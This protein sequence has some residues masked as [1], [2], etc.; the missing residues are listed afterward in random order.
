MFAKGGEV[1]FCSSDSPHKLGCEY[2]AGG[3][4]VPSEMYNDP[5]A[6][7][8]HA[9]IHHGL[10]GVLTRL[11]HSK[12]EDPHK[13]VKDY[14]EHAKRGSKTLHHHVEHL[15]TPERVAHD[16]GSREAL[17]AH[18]Q[19]L[20]EHPEKLLEVGGS[21]GNTLPHHAAQFGATA[22]TATSYLDSLKPSSQPNPIPPSPL[23]SAP[24]EDRI[25]EGHYDRHLDLAQ[26]PMLALNHIKD[27]TFREDDLKTLQ[28]IYPSLS[29]ALISKASEALV[30]AKSKN[31]EIPY[32]QKQTLSVL[33]GQPLDFTMTP[34]AMQAIIHSAPVPQAPQ[35]PGKGP[36]KATGVEL[37][38]INKVNNL[39]ATPLQAREMDKRD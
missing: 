24:P 2:F 25:A 32:K 6:T 35:A 34:Q 20:K 37:K 36:K 16:K 18:L 1:H 13:G 21:I 12:S 30:T 31:V 19:D 8:D 17:K 22:G 9:A 15:F 23:D 38:Q 33:F 29:K 7:I 4:E 28:T 10:L 26:N 39:D 27:G 11:G 3:G 5:G 14:V